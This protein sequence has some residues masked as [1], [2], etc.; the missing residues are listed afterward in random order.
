MKK[1][2][3]ELQWTNK[4]KSL[5][6]DLEKKEYIWVD[7]KDPRVY[8]PRILVEK[9]SNGDTDSENLLIKG[10]NL[11]ALKALQQ[12]YQNKV[13]LVYIDPPFNTGQAFEYYEDGLEHSIWL[14][15]MRDRLDLLK[16]LMRKD[17]IIWIHVDD[18]ESHYCKILMDEIFGRQN[19]LANIAYERSGSAGIGQGGRFLVNTH[20]YMVV[21]AKDVTKLLNSTQ[22]LTQMPLEK[23][24]MVRYKH[25]LEDEGEKEL[26]EE[27]VSKSNGEK[28][29]IYKH[30][31]YKLTSIPL[32]D[33]DN[34]QEEIQEDYAKNFLKIF[35]TTNPQKENSFQHELLSKMDKQLYSV[36]YTPS[37][38]KSKDKKVTNYYVNREI[39]AWLKDTASIVDGKI[40]KQ[41]K[42]T[43][44][45]YHA[46]IP[47]AD[48]ANEGSVDFRRGK[49]PENL[50]KRVIDLSTTEGDLV[51]DSFAGSG[52]TGAVA[53][54]MKRNWVM[55]EMGEHAESHIIPRLKKVV[56]G[57]DQSGISKEVGWKGGN[58]FKYFELG[59]SLFVQDDDL[60]Y[61]IINPK[62]YNGKL[63]RAVLKVEGFKPFN[64]DNGLH[65]LSGSTAA[66]VTEQYL[67]QDYVNVLLNEIGNR[68]DYLVI[69]AK[70]ISSSLKLPD[71]VE[72][73]R[74]PE[75]LLKRFSI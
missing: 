75:V 63:I 37:R 32:R 66:H 33:F 15:M 68:A 20:E 7:K 43:D 6:Y 24:V 53:H 62:M 71:N 50:I 54:K 73:K 69:Y 51:L 39:F 18:S 46:D 65:G 58:G 60:R 61:T 44:F 56:S 47:K 12:D 48:L 25:V 30:K 9:E 2:K 67:T 27:Y 36:N 64:P 17:G 28:I 29:A 40:V 72:V 8:E 10:D 57:A 1:T 74:M 19:Y 42:M 41:N 35:R 45:W 26:V 4:E 34:R 5:F 70:T 59:D 13:K 38:G 22:A 14:T 21:Y 31:N 16:R 55:V 23:K 49:K 52:T 3:L 11:L